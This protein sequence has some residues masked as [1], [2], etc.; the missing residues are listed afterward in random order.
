MI[1]QRL[2]VTNFMCYRQAALD[3]SGIHVACLIGDNGAG[4]SALLDALTWAVWGRSRARR[5]DDLILQG[6]TEMG[7]EFVFDLEGRAYRI[8]R[9]R[10]SGKRS[11]SSLEFHVEH[12]DQWRSLV[13][14]GIRATQEEIDRTLRLDYDTFVNSAFLRQGHADEFT[15]KTA[16][17]RKRVLGAILGLDRWSVYEARAREALGR[18]EREAAMLDARLAE[19][20]EELSKRT[21][22]EADL[23]AAESI[24][25]EMSADL[26][27]AQEAFQDLEAARAE[28]RQLEE[29]IEDAQGRIR[30]AEREISRHAAERERR[31]AKMADAER[32]LVQ[33]EEIAAGYAAY[34]Q[35]VRQ[36][37]ELGARLLQS[38]EL[39]DRR[40]AIEAELAEARRVIETERKVTLRQVSE[41]RA[42]LNLDALLAEQE[43]LTAQIAHLRQLEES[44]EAA[45][46]DLTL[47]TEEQSAARA[48]NQVLR[49]EMEQ[50][51]DRIQWLEAAGAECPLCRQPLTEAHR[52]ELIQ[53]AEHE[54]RA[55]GDQYRAN[56]AA[57]QRLSQRSQALQRQI[58]DADR[59]L[60]GL[61]A[62]ERQEAAVAERIALAATDREALAVEER[63]LQALS[64]RLDSEDYGQEHR[65]RLRDVLQEAVALGYDVAAH[66]AARQAVS[67][68]E[69]YANRQAELDHALVGIEE[70]QAALDQLDESIKRWYEQAEAER[71]LQD[72][73][74]KQ[75]AALR[76]RM[77]DAEA[78]EQA[79]QR[80]RGDEAAIRQRLGAAQQRLEACKTL[81]RQR[82]ERLKRLEELAVQKEIYTELRTAFGVKGV[83]AMI[84]ESVV[85]EI[86]S[87]ANRLLERMTDGRMHVSFEMQRET[88]SGAMQETLEIHISDE[89]GT[90]PYESYSGGEQFRADFAIRVAL[91]RL[92]ARRR[93]AQ[94]Q[95][96]V[97]D[98]GFGSQDEQGRERLVEAIH[99]VQDE[100]ERILVVTHVE[101]LK[102]A[103]PVRIEVTKTRQGSCV[104]VV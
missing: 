37:R 86:A 33:R 13:G 30:R 48:H 28:M 80:M 79:L 91:S 78:V 87:E 12:D 3:F 41:L 58:A 65:Q 46:A 42:R 53:Q 63:K 29:R 8:V 74:D 96:L 14:G 95:M 43:Q 77:T 90:R 51:K 57:S 103:F 20:G 93:G 73:L 102:D 56:Q 88:L 64:R 15:V 61:V 76:D 68:G 94:L 84:I 98:E 99:A 11:G 97:I 104:V 23:R 9:R 34:Q 52:I 54:G 19:I 85:P 50:L 7:V 2:F 44:R 71:N 59:L 69:I 66:E 32:V 5:D 60:G 40:Q 39:N 24:A 62:L 10:R 1:P 16:S 67:E 21:E 17:E 25:A 26:V 101:E 70:E 27:H 81:E 35:A 4:K 89:L 72:G 75:T 36:E 49:S 45:R 31:L 92:L 38:V 100:F 83:P 47:I 55:K 6:E 82:G 18:V 22:Y